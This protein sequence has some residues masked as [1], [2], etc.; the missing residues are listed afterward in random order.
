MGKNNIVLCLK[1]ENL[2]ALEYHIDA[3]Y[4]ICHDIKGHTGASI[5]MGV[6]NLQKKP[7]KQKNNV[8]SSTKYELV[9]L[10]DCMPQV[11]Y[12]QLIL[13]IIKDKNK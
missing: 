10:D 8:K 5:Y 13:F 3:S 2:N 11:L 12:G 1:V 6:G 4:T 9:G 7:I